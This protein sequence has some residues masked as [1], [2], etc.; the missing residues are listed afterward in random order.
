MLLLLK[1]FCSKQTQHVAALP[2]LSL[3]HFPLFLRSVARAR[4]TLHGPRTAG[5]R[6]PLSLE[7]SRQ[8]WNTGVTAV[9][10]PRDLLRPGVTP[11]SLVSPALAGGLFTTSATWETHLISDMTMRY[12]SNINLL[13]LM[14]REEVINLKKLKIRLQA[15]NNSTKIWC[16]IDEINIYKSNSVLLM[17]CNAWKRSWQYAGSLKITCTTLVNVIKSTM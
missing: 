6:V 14:G 12:S 17:A 7:F 9:S 3:Q 2:M 16:V 5:L 10:F 1:T 11:M 4:S 15:N 13:Y 8:E